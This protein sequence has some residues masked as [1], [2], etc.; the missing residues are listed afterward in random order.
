MPRSV[1]DTLLATRAARDRLAE[2]HQPYW[3]GMRAGAALGYRKGSTAG[4]WLVR[5]AD[6]SAGG[7]YRQASLGRADDTLKADGVKILDYRK[8]EANAREW[9][10]RHHRVTAGKNRKAAAA[11]ATPYTVANTISDYLADY[12][13]RGGKAIRTTL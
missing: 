1:A 9:I 6:P 8:A 2:R 4:V 13:E 7:G 5:V 3:R 12:V 11:P 10:A